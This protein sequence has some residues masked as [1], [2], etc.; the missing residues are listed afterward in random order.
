MASQQPIQTLGEE[1]NAIEA[2]RHKS[3]NSI[4]GCTQDKA[5]KVLMLHKSLHSYADSMVGLHSKQIDAQ[6]ATD[7]ATTKAVK[8]MSADEH[9]KMQ[10]KIGKAQGHLEEHAALTQSANDHAQKAAKLIAD[11][12]QRYA[13]TG[14]NVPNPV[15]SGSDSNVDNDAG[16]SERAPGKKKSAT[17]DLD[18]SALLASLSIV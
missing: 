17:E 3:V 13:Q 9:M 5:S 12:S 15:G 6:D 14:M 1:R 10:R 18:Y 4:M 7:T 16:Q 8:G 11:V 2:A